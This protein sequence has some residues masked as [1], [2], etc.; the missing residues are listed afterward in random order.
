MIA[1]E[2]PWRLAGGK[3]EHHTAACRV[4]GAGVAVPPRRDCGD[5]KCHRKDTAG[6]LA[7]KAQVRVKRRGKS[8]PLAEEFARQEKP[9]AG[10]DKTGGGQPV[11]RPSGSSHHAGL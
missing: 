7:T 10:Q 5:G 11:R 3:S 8:S 6:S 1:G 9:H 4:K 2:P